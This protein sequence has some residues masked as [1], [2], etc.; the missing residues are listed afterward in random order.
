MTKHKKVSLWQQFCLYMHYGLKIEFSER[1]R[2]LS[3]LLFAAT[4]LIVIAFCFAT[5]A[6]IEN[7]VFVAEIYLAVFLALQVSGVR[8]LEY[9]QR[10]DV[11][12]LLCTYPITREIVY[13]SKFLLYIMTSLLMLIPALALTYLFNA[14]PL[15]NEF[16]YMLG[17]A[18]LVLVGLAALGVL[19]SA[20]VMR[21]SSRHLLYPL[22][23]FPLTI[24]LLIAAAEVSLA[25]LTHGQINDAQLQWVTL[26]LGFDV[27]Y[28]T[29]G[30]LLFGELL[31]G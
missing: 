11:L 25:F 17:I 31:E 5:T 14:R 26:L 12:T 18:C 2:L 24:P 28:F 10:N 30:V 6:Q 13:L 15:T 8:L 7:R 16:W 3:P 19:L 21:S 20:L 23:Y 1:E 29:L 4:I 22:L 27:I 9:E